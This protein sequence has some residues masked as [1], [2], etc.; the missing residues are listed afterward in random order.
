LAVAL[1]VEVYVQNYT[2][3]QKPSKGAVLYNIC[4]ICWIYYTVPRIFRI[5][6]ND[7]HLNSQCIT[8]FK[9]TRL[10][11]NSKTWSQKLS[12]IT[13]PVKGIM[14]LILFSRILYCLW[15]G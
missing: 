13:V 7:S 15:R 4:L 14:Y 2:K 5:N 8:S 12:L 6:L 3:L 10:I 11:S 9:L 1:S